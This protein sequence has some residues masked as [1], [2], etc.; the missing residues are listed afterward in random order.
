MAKKQKHK[1]RSGVVFSTNP[2][3]NYQY[4]AEAEAETL[5]PA[6]QQLRVWLDRKGGGKVATVVKGFIGTTDDL[7]ALGKHLKTK[8][9]VG[10]AVKDEEII[11]QGDH[12]DK[13]VNLLKAE[14]YQA[15]KAGG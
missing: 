4:E 12:R 8:C 13:V 9:G 7:K 5:Q 11:I 1:G 14:G 10:G 6:Q 3:F 2:D 15:K